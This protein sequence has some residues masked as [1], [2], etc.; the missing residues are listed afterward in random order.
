MSPLLKIARVMRLSLALGPLA[1]VG[2][3]IPTPLPAANPT[4]TLSLS[5]VIEAALAQSAVARQ[6]RTN[7]EISYWQF[8]R[9]QADYRPQVALQ[10]TLPNFSRVI[11]PV[12]QPDGTTGFRA[13]RLNNATLGLGLTQAIGPTG[14]QLTLGTSLQR[15]DDFNGGARLYNN[16]PFT[17]GLSQPLGRYNALRWN[18]RIEPLRYQES[19]RQFAAEREAI[20]QRTTE[21]YFDVLLQQVNAATAGQNVQANQE[22]Y[23]LGQERHQLG[24]LSQSDLLLLELNVLSARQAQAQAQL[25]AQNAALLLQEY[26]GLLAETLAGGALTVPAPAP[27]PLVAP[28]QALTQARQHRPETLA[29][30]RRLLEAESAV[31]QAR[32]TTGLQA[33][34]VASLGYVNSAPDFWTT[35]QGLQNQQQLSLTFSKPLLDWGRQRAIVRTAQ[36]TRAQTQADVAQDERTFAQR[37]LT[38]AAQLGTLREQLRLGAA[39]DSLAR[40]RYGIARATYAVGRISLTDLNIA[41]AQKD[42]TQRAYLAALRAAW[43]AHYRL[44]ALTLFDFET[45]QPLGDEQ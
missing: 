32:G 6:A 30:Q 23:R 40:Q 15:Y 16:Q 12:V 38:Q 27:T 8:R 24:R 17:L 36:L 42:Q 33:A 13:V 2:Q 41:L 22:L 20:A 31:A 39:A 14:A 4:P 45:G 37:V 1:T 18:R 25:D 26:T 3:R 34:L 9:Y 5:A 10:G 21:L 7:R 35:Y 43:V 44:R 11:T 19:R 28:D 29:F